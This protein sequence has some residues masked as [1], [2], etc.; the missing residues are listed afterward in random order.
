M[1]HG[2]GLVSQFFDGTFK[3]GAPPIRSPGVAVWVNV[4]SFDGRKVV[5]NSPDY[6]VEL[7]IWDTLGVCGK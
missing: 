7:V 4:S 2:S 3:L 6:L 1:L 5:L